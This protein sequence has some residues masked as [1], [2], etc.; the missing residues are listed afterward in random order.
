VSV[1]AAEEGEQEQMKS[2][3]M[4]LGKLE[5]MMQDAFDASHGEPLSR[6]LCGN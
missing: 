2:G 3:A 1:R 4:G 6:G 5:V